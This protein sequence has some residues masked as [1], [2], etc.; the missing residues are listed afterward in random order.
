M[1]GDSDGADEE[2]AGDDY[3]DGDGP[4]KEADPNLTAAAQDVMSALENG[5]P[6]EFAEGLRSFVSMC[7]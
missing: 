1:R 5:D 6:G 2:G 7:D 3:D 4:D